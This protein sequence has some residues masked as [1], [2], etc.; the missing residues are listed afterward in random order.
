MS[1]SKYYICTTPPEII[2]F[3]YPRPPYDRRLLSPAIAPGRPAVCLSVCGMSITTMFALQ[4]FTDFSYQLEICWMMHSTMEQIAIKM[5][6]LSPFCVFH[7]TLK[8]CMIGFYWPGLM[9]DVTTLTLSGSQ[10]KAWHLVRWCTVTWSISL[11]KMVMLS[12]FLGVSASERRCYRSNSLRISG[13]SLKFGGMMHSN[14]KQIVLKEDML[15]SFLH[16]A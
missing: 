1:V 2:K 10:L 5:A 8:F 7:G 13:V 14:M 12:Q 15:G 11:L 4:L 16:I 9:D 6:M 3:Y